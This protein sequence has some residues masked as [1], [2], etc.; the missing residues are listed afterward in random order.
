M[1]SPDS[2]NIIT[3]S[4][5]VGAFILGVVVTFLI[6]A[7]EEEPNVGFNLHRDKDPLDA[8]FEETLEEF[9]SGIGTE[10]ITIT[11]NELWDFVELGFWLGVNSYTVNMG[12]MVAYYDFQMTRNPQGSLVSYTNE[13]ITEQCERQTNRFSLVMRKKF[14]NN[15][16]EFKKTFRELQGVL[17]VRADA[18]NPN[19]MCPFEDA[20]AHLYDTSVD[21]DQEE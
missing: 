12:Q 13:F 2:R 9:Q 3:A 20:G 17:G 5:V 4:M 21:V 1:N 11:K 18:E 19:V 15:S 16:S 14:E 7:T 8:V 6:G 10:S